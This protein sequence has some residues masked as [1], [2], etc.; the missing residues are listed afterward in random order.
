MGATS[1]TANAGLLRYGGRIATTAGRPDISV[2]PPFSIGPSTHEIALGAAYTHGDDRDVQRL[3][4]NLGELLA[5]VGDGK[6][7]PMVDHTFPLE[8]VPDALTAMS[9]RRLIGKAV[10]AA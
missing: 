8:Q 10:Y 5:L 3:G 9:E 7:R 4:A 1:A 2:V 6:L